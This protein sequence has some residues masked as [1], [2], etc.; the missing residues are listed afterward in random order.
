MCKY[1]GTVFLLMS[2]FSFSCKGQE[3]ELIQTSKIS[4]LKEECYNQ[5]YFDNTLVENDAVS[6]LYILDHENS[7]I[8]VFNMT[9]LTYNS[10][11]KLNASNKYAGIWTN[12]VDSIFCTLQN[13][14]KVALFDLKGQLLQY[15]TIDIPVAFP[16]DIKSFPHNKL[17][18]TKNKLYLNL[19]YRLNSPF[20]IPYHSDELIY[21]NINNK[22]EVYSSYPA[23]YKSDKWWHYIGYNVSKT[24]NSSGQVILSYPIVDTMYIY[25]NK[26]VLINRI[27][28]PSK[29][30]EGYTFK[31]YDKNKRADIKYKNEYVTT[32]G[33]YFNV[34][35][36]KY[37]NLYY[38]IVLHPQKYV[39]SDN[40]L[41]TTDDNPWSIIVMD[42]NF[43]ILTE[44][45]MPPKLY[46]FYTII[47]TSKG[48]L[49]STN[50]SLN[51]D[52]EDKKIGF[53]NF[54]L[55]KK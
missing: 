29:F 25:T 31:A 46:D 23:I 50:H 20:D 9:N 37:F 34:I 47:P 44:Q 10:T 1:L 4:I 7:C 11:I 24:V 48:L 16:Y 18:Y 39:N 42:S 6:K 26:G 21:D 28:C 32:M 41:N 38:R 2:I 27:P 35:Y 12:G 8:D 51:K 19:Q 52:N 15:L 30:L 55:I 5:Y 17:S 53:V 49:I 13:S 54:K 40:T 45:Y 22:S 36:D 43:K 3:Y 33:R 14:N